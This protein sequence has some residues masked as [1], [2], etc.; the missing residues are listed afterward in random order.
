VLRDPLVTRIGAAHNK[1]PAQVALRWLAQQRIAAVTASA[2][3]RH[4]REVLQIGDFTLSDADMRA[5]GAL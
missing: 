3:P 5:L 2:K 4:L 1:S